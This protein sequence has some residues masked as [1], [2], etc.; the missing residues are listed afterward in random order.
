MG[1]SLQNT[2]NTSTLYKIGSVVS[3][4][5]YSF[6]AVK[7]TQGNDPSNASLTKS[8]NRGLKMATNNIVVF[9]HDDII[10]E[11]NGWATKLVNH[12][13]NSD[14]YVAHNPQ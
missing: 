9:C 1:Y 8:Y 4:G 2:W 14:F 5:G 7:D 3:R 6:T 13:Q 10:F 12:F 11:K